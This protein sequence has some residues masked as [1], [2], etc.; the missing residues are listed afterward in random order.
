MLIIFC[1]TKKCVTV[2]A[3]EAA[4]VQVFVAVIYARA[5]HVLKTNGTPSSLT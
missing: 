5:I 1:M 2:A 3:N 4:Y